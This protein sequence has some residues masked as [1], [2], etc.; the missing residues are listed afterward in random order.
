VCG[1]ERE[2]WRGD[3]GVERRERSGEEREEWSSERVRE[4]REVIE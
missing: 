1:E 2:E 4:V 3:R